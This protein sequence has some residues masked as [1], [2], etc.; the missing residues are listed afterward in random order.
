MFASEHI[1]L[2][3]TVCALEIVNQA[4]RKSR[5]GDKGCRWAPRDIIFTDRSLY[6]FAEAPL[7]PV[8]KGGSSLG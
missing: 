4:P 5:Q 2:N 8:E 6:I 1:L 7:P 3:T